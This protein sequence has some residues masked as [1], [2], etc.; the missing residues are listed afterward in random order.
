LENI[1]IATPDAPT[2][3][4][5]GARHENGDATPDPDCVKAKA[6]N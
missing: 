1:A 5:I 3:A 4:V 6:R 2:L